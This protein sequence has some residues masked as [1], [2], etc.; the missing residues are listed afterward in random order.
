MTVS[1]LTIALGAAI[2]ATSV[3][4]VACSG[5]DSSPPANNP[6]NDAS[7][8][9]DTGTGN[10]PDA[11]GGGSNDS[12]N[13]SNPSDPGNVQCGGQACNTDANVCC[14]ALDGG[15]TCNS[16]DVDCTGDSIEVGCDESADCTDPANPVCCGS[17][18]AS[19]D[20]SVECAASCGGAD[21]GASLS[22]QICKT[23]AE[24]GAAGACVTQTCYGV[25]VSTC[26][27]IPEAVCNP[28]P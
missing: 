2:F 1:R 18:T 26:G 5:D 7:T 13:P 17:I 6:G 4:F 15:G 3:A 10:T 22:R 19:Q 8:G 9:N 25:V 12:G 20:F 16:G 24:C 21:A 14:R 27:G 23:N 11:G 28:P